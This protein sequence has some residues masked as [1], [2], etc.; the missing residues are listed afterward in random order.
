MPKPTPEAIKEAERLVDELNNLSVYVLVKSNPGTTVELNPIQTGDTPRQLD[1][2]LRKNKTNFWFYL[3]VDGWKTGDG[4]ISEFAYQQ[5]RRMSAWY[6]TKHHSPHEPAFPSEGVPDKQSRP[7]SEWDEVFH[8]TLFGAVGARG[9]IQGELEK[10]GNVSRRQNLINAL[11][12]RYSGFLTR[13]GQRKKDLWRKH[14]REHQPIGEDGKWLS[15]ALESKDDEHGTPD[16]RPR[17]TIDFFH[18]APED[19]DKP[20]V[21]FEGKRGFSLGKEYLPSGDPVFYDETVPDQTWGY[22]DLTGKDASLTEHK[23]HQPLAV[24]QWTK[25]N[26]KVIRWEAGDAAADTWEIIAPL[27]TEI[28]GLSVGKTYAS[29]VEEVSKN[30]CISPQAARKRIRE[31]SKSKTLKGFLLES[32]KDADHIEGQRQNLEGGLIRYQR[33]KVPA[34]RDDD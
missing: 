27:I 12:N 24:G 5:L 34:D 17:H 1:R 19:Q 30:A 11:L 2:I 7:L 33:P 4:E 3:L 21:T 25:K 13:V 16:A 10:Y 14:Y 9:N 22:P 20:A 23:F 15:P 28:V 29:L 26:L 18:W 32:I 31:L 6:L 8:F